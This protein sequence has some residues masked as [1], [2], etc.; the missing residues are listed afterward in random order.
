MLNEQQNEGNTEIINQRKSNC[1]CNYFW[2]SI[3]VIYC[4]IDLF[5]D[6]DCNER[7]QR[8]DDVVI[9]HNLFLRNVKFLLTKEIKTIK[10]A[11]KFAAEWIG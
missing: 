9:T 8:R 2:I 11:E 7:K 1:V 3:G 6:N 4:G 10:C 5:A